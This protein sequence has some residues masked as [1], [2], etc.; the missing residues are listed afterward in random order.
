MSVSGVAQIRALFVE[1]EEVGPLGRYGQG[2]WEG[3]GE[4]GCYRGEPCAVSGFFPD[5]KCVLGIEVGLHVQYGV[6]ERQIAGGKLVR[7][8]GNN[9]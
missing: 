7:F 5:P 9:C 6:G 3:R 1:A 2:R 4:G 8:V